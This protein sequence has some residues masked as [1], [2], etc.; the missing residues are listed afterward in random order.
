MWVKNVAILLF[1]LFLSGICVD[2]EQCLS[3]I[4]SQ[5]VVVI[6][7]VHGS[8]SFFNILHAAGITALPTEC[9]WKASSEVFLFMQSLYISVHYDIFRISCSFKWVILWIVV[10]MHMKLGD[11]LRNF[12][13]KHPMDQK[14]SD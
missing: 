2:N 13:K 11:A 3:N 1:S 12:S 10:P 14:L 9:S 6:G 5:R 8:L 7:D 4:R